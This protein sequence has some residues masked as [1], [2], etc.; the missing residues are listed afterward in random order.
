VPV[1]DDS[2]RRALHSHT[3]PTATSRKAKPT[4]TTQSREIEGV[5]LR[6]GSFYGPGTVYDCGGS[7]HEDV[8]KRRVPIVGSG[9]GVF[10]FIHVDDA[11]DATVAALETLSTGV[12]Q[13][14]DDDPAPL[15]DWLPFY[16]DLVGAPRPMRIPVFLARLAAGPFGV[17]L[18][19]EQRGASNRL[20]KEKLGWS[21]NHASWKEGF[22]AS[23]LHA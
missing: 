2:W 9:S 14:V 15:R 1:L 21:P 7:F 6:Y 17:Y 20:A 13:I 11:A 4:L 8:K 12:F 23:L 19:V 16:A 22:R 10:S 18:M 3:G 5:V